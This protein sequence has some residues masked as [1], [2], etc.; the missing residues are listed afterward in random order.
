[1]RKYVV[2][3]RIHTKK[4]R[5]VSAPKIPNVFYVN[6]NREIQHSTTPVFDPMAS[7]PLPIAII[8]TSKYR[9]WKLSSLYF[10]VGVG[11]RFLKNARNIEL[12]A[13]DHK[14]HF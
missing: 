10:G 13:F 11:V 8:T 4:G 3:M 14:Y 12:L 5:L 2:T 7:K 1:M 9:S 6:E